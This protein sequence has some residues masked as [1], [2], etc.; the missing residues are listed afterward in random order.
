MKTELELN[1]YCD[2]YVNS[3]EPAAF[4][5]LIEIVKNAIN[6][7]P[8]GICEMNNILVE[9]LGPQKSKELFTSLEKGLNFNG[10]ANLKAFFWPCD[11]LKKYLKHR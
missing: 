5:K 4:E 9:K 11:H 2:I 7:D 10:Y 1:K 3:K 6:L 8:L